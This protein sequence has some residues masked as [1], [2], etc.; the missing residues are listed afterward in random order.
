VVAAA[1]WDRV[2]V[3]VEQLPRDG[4]AR[5]LLA[6]LTPAERSQARSA[7]QPSARALR[8][9]VRKECLVKAGEV[10]PAGMAHVDLSRVAE[11][12]DGAGRSVSRYRGLH[13]VDWWDPAREVLVAVA[14][15]A[16]PLTCSIAEVVDGTAGWS[17]IP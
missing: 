15:A 11:R 2:G 12:I 16:A 10:A 7:A 13:L 1:A 14:G 8:Y 9:W 5:G 4:V 17:T 3:D 6:V